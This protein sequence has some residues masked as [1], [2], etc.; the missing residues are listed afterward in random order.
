MHELR[1]LLLSLID[2]RE[3]ERERNRFNKSLANKNVMNV[4]SVLVVLDNDD[5]PNKSQTRQQ[6]SLINGHLKNVKNRFTK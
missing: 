3:R 4:M 2:D 5:R 1:F 6:S